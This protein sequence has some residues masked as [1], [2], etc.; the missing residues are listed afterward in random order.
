MTTENGKYRNLESQISTDVEPDDLVTD[1]EDD[2]PSES[3][4]LLP[5]AKPLKKPRRPSRWAIII[6]SASL[7]VSIIMLLFVLLFKYDTEVLSGRETAIPFSDNAIRNAVTFDLPSNL[8]FEEDQ[9][10]VFK[11]SVPFGLDFD[12]A[13]GVDGLGPHGIV[14]PIGGPLQRSRLA[15]GRSLARSIS[16]LEVVINYPISIEAKSS[17]ESVEMFNITLLDTLSVPI[18]PGLQKSNSEIKHSKDWLSDLEIKASITPTKGSEF[19]LEGLQTFLEHVWVAEKGVMDVSIVVPQVDI[20][21]WNG[22]ALHTQF[23]KNNIHIQD[24]LA[25]PNLEPWPKPGTPIV[26]TYQQMLKLLNL[27]HLNIGMSNNTDKTEQ[28]EVDA[29]ASFPLPQLDI[30]KSLKD[31]IFPYEIPIDAE[32]PLTGDEGSGALSLATI[33]SKPVTVV[34]DELSFGGKAA[35]SLQLKTLKKSPTIKKALS[36]FLSNFLNNTPTPFMIRGGAVKDINTPDWLRELLAKFEYSFKLPGVP[37]MPDIVRNVHMENLH[38]RRQSG[39]PWPNPL[40][41]QPGGPGQVLV[42]GTLIADIALPH[43][44]RALPIN[45]NSILPDLVIFNGAPPPLNSSVSM[46]YPSNAF[47]VLSPEEP[48]EAYT[49]FADDPEDEDAPQVTRLYAEVRNAPIKLLEGRDGEFRSFM[50]KMLFGKAT[51]GV[52]GLATANGGLKNVKDFEAVDI[53]KIKVNG[54]FSANLPSLSTSM[55]A[56]G[57]NQDFLFGNHNYGDLPLKADHANRPLWVSPEDGHIIL[58][59]FSPIAE[60]AQDFLVAIAEP[61]SRTS[62]MEEYKVTPYSLYAAVS[63]GLETADIIEVLNRLSK[64]PVPQSIIDFIKDCTM[65]YGKVKLVLK[66]NRYFVESADPETLQMLLRD[67]IIKNARVDSNAYLET[68]TAPTKGNLVIPGTKEAHSTNNANTIEAAPVDE[69]QADKQKKQQEKEHGDDY[70]TALIDIE[71]QDEMEDD[72]EVHSFEIK[73]EEIETVKRRCNELEYPM[74]EEYDFHNDTRNPNLDID[75]KPVTVIRPYQ[76]KSLSKMF[77]N[78]RARSGIIVLPCGAGKTLVGITAACT[79]KKSVLVLCTSSVS[80]MQWKQQF[81]QWSNVN[82]SQIS[83]FTA[84]QKEKFGGESGIVVSTYSMVA[85]TRNRSHESQ[86]MMDFLTSREWGFILL[87]EV[88]VVPAAMFR[89][90]VTTIKAHSK[91]GLTATLV[92]EDDKIDDLN[93]LIGPKLYEANW[94]DLAAKGHIANVQCAEVWCPMVPCFYREYLREKSRKRMLLYSM[95]PHKFQACQF[96]IDF[97]EDRGDKIIVFS[98]CVYSLEQYARKLK[99][100][101]IHGGTSQVE[102]MRVLQRFQYD[103]N[104]NTIFLSK[105]GDTSID[106]PE[107]TCLIQISSHFGSRRQEA[108]RLGRILRA[109]RRND[110][111]FNAFFYSL[112]STDTQEMFYSTKRQGFLVDQ[113]Y[114][115]KVI[116]HLFGIERLP[117]LVYRSEKEQIELLESVLLANESAADIGSDIKASE[118]DLAGTIHGVTKRMTGNTSALAGGQA[119]SYIE[120]NKSANKQITND[121][122]HS[123]FKKRDKE[124][125]DRAKKKRQRL[126]G[127][128]YACQYKTG[129]VLGSGSYSSV[130]LAVHIKTGEKYAVKVINKKM[131][132]GREDLIRNEIA[133]LKRASTGHHN[134]VRLIDY[135]ET[136]NNL[137]LVMDLCTGG[138]L[139]DEIC[140]RG[141]FFEKDA[142]DIIAV[143]ADSVSYLHST[144]IVHR[145]LK[146]ENLLF[147]NDKA[148]PNDLC[149]ADFGL[150][151]IIE[152]GKFTQ[153]YQICGTVGYMAPEVFMRVGHGFPVDIWAIGVITF[154]LLSGTTPFD[155]GNQKEEINAILDGNYKFE[156]AEY[157]NAVSETAKD[158]IKGCMNTDPA[159]RLTAKQVLEHP[160]LKGLGEKDEDLLP[161]VRRAFDAKR[162]FRAAVRSVQWINRLRSLDSSE[163]EKEEYRQQVFALQQEAEKEVLG[164]ESEVTMHAI[165]P[166]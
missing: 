39:F 44:L 107:A 54:E 35:T 66:H 109:K 14:D 152:S 91:L 40:P 36:R 108:Q 32:L 22:T 85:N 23:Q 154:F 58:E 3:S 119:M 81:M 104:V 62:L 153:L 31:V 126:T 105:V 143:I 12:Q 132:E 144:G 42:S 16:P 158:F 98:D 124:A 80:V 138:E 125:A 13:L 163:E 41:G 97:H 150:S 78:G 57:V 10:V 46:A 127:E 61:V 49:E 48:F 121:S 50:G 146:P 159:K 128:A 89:R 70:F 55:T 114:A 157:W 69:E 116:T 166:N 33:T 53:K 11:T 79:I 101:Y 82:D 160:W 65:S 148:T 51:V 19:D 26:E 84:D 17:N 56:D 155:R 115:F 134:I 76:E 95:N 96:L 93:F 87:D 88:H 122:R 20:H 5:N 133:V 162:S 90:V 71:K 86:K 118:D 52:D 1:D 156:P 123:L 9:P 29:S 113:G 165:P 100:P 27:K 137:Y 4:P 117:D 45:V 2:L 7:V 75:L 147:R 77:G 164:P 24:R 139:F 67:Q 140:Q 59:G 102:R 8:T 130:K 73:S 18:T 120:K 43:Q 142:K 38:V 21:I 25:I 30:I 34:D 135:F 129:E 64:V 63:V 60:Q 149:V 68:S 131:M 37:P 74:L 111:G 110:E 106:L 83:V 145:D 72:E 99:K 92:R 47:A 161:N 28:V 15:I 112:V 6:W 103:S 136:M 151:K 94:M 141:H